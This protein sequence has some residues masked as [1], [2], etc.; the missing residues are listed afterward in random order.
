M[1]LECIVKIGCD[2]IAAA[3]AWNRAGSAAG[4]AAMGDP[5]SRLSVSLLNCF[6]DIR[7]AHAYPLLADLNDLFR[8]DRV[9]ARATLGVQKL[10]QFLQRFRIGGAAQESAFAPDVY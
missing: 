5:K 2:R 7:A 10:Q 8:P 6:L 3:A 1:P 4:A 9:I